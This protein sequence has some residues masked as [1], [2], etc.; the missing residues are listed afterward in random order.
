[1]PNRD[2]EFCGQT[3]IRSP[4]VDRNRKGKASQEVLLLRGRLNS[5]A[6]ANVVSQTVSAFSFLLSSWLP[7][8]DSSVNDFPL[9]D[10][11]TKGPDFQKPPK[12]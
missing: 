9:Q 10:F 7:F 11:A 8:E 5:W 2:G 6:L 12:S 3:F 1:M 4:S